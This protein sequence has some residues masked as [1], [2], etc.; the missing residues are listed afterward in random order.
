VQGSAAHFAVGILVDSDGDDEYKA[1]MNMAQGAGHDFSLGFLLDKAG[2]D[3]YE[4]PNLS[5]GAGNANGIGIFWDMAGNDVYQTRGGTTMGGAN[6][7]TVGFRGFML[8][9]GVFIDSGGKDTYPAS[10]S[11]V[12]NDRIWTQP[13]PAGMQANGMTRGVGLDQ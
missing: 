13:P 7:E 4:A 6:Y 11:Y 9:L 8:C 3:H 1:T 5:L 12:G 2:D 10:I